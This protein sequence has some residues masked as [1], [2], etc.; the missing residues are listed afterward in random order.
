ME[1]GIGPHM[2]KKYKY[3]PIIEA[4]CEFRFGPESHW[5]LTIPGLV[6]EKVRDNFPKRRQA[7]HFSLKLSAKTQAE[8]HTAE[9]IHFL[10][11]D[12]KALIQ[13]GPHFLA[14][15]YL[16]PYNSWEEFLPMIEQGLNAY[17]NIAEPLTIK[18]VGLRYIN[19]IVIEIPSD[20]PL[21]LHEFFNVYPFTK[22]FPQN[23]LNSF[24][25]G[26]QVPYEEDRDNLKLTLSSLD[27]D[28]ESL[29]ENLVLLDLDYFLTEPEAITPHEATKW[30]E[31]AHAHLEKAF[32]S[33]IT[34]KLR[35][36]FEEI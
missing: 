21:L 6:F 10:R 9:R 11:D 27:L 5:D 4:V 19:H 2:G 28:T 34:D 29:N 14:V 31:T 20:S 15:N 35:L 7:Q 25:V 18:R 23:L 16:K 17:Q 26:I 32:E 3:P 30:V 22:N 8:V 13:V 36:V 33:A 1:Q 12:E 24:N